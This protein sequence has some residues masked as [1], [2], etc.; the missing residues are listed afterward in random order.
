MAKSAPD[1]E[2]K[3]SGALPSHVAKGYRVETERQMQKEKRER[4]AKKQ[5]SEKQHFF[6][7]SPGRKRGKKSREEGHKSSSSPTK[8]EQEWEKAALGLSSFIRGRNGGGDK[9][10]QFSHPRKLG[11]N[12]CRP[13]FCICLVV[14]LLQHP[15]KGEKGK[16]RIVNICTMSLAHL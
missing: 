4:G 12:F 7:I 15:R 1:P 5:A 10:D 13:G 3:A 8:K 2:S 6:F 14:L 16:Q 9:G 11:G